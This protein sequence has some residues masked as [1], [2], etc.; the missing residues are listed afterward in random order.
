MGGERRVK[1]VA[2]GLTVV[3]ARRQQID[4]LH[5][6]RRQIDDFRLH[7]KIEAVNRLTAHEKALDEPLEIAEFLGSKCA[8]LQCSRL[9]M[10]AFKRNAEAIVNACSRVCVASLSF[11]KPGI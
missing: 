9:L 7:D 1:L 8:K 10:N 3:D 4:D 5:E 6:I 2:E 11:V